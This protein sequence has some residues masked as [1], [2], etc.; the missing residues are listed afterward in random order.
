MESTVK[1]GRRMAEGLIDFL[2]VNFLYTVAG[3]NNNYLQE[4]DQEE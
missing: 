1:T 4:L 2:A 3:E